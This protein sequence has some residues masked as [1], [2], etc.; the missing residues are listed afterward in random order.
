VIAALAIGGVILLAIICVNW[1]GWV[2]LPSDALVPIHWGGTW[3]SFVSKRAGL[4]VH[5]AAGVG[6]YLLLAFVSVAS[7]VHGK[8]PKVPVD[9]IL[10]V[11]MGVLLI[12][13]AGAI[14]VARRRSAADGVGPG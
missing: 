4:A 5:L 2:S 8:P 10:P 9:F 7:P 11:V 1:Y 14:K 3:G 6:I 12:T 13:Q